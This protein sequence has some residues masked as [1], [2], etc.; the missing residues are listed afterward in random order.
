MTEISS[1][2]YDL[3]LKGSSVLWCLM[4]TVILLL[5]IISGP[6][7]TAASS[8]AVAITTSATRSYVD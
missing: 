1:L 5:L 3:R 2:N 7:A 6:A 4:A 8:V